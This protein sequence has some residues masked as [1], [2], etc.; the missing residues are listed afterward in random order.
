MKL[1][2]H[3]VAAC[4]VL[5]LWTEAN[6]ADGRAIQ[7][8]IRKLES[9]MRYERE[10]AAA[11]LRQANTIM[12]LRLFKE[13]F[14]MLRYEGRVAFQTGVIPHLLTKDVDTFL[15]KE[16]RSGFAVQQKVQELEQRA[17]REGESYELEAIYQQLGN[18][19][20]W[21]KWVVRARRD[22][23]YVPTYEELYA[24][25]LKLNER[26]FPLSTFAKALHQR[27]PRRAEADFQK[28]LFNPDGRMKLRGI[29]A[30]EAA[31]VV[32]PANVVL[33]FF[34]RADV[35]LLDQG[36]QF[37]HKLRREHL[38][39]LLSLVAS[40]SK[41]VRGMAE[42]RLRRIGHITS[43]EAGKLVANAA[44][45]E[46]RAEAWRLWWAKHKND[47]DEALRGRCVAVLVSEA[48]SKFTKRMLHE[49]AGYGDHA[50]VYPI[51][52]EAISS[53][54]VN[55]R[56]T[57]IMQLGNMA[58]R[59]HAAAADALIGHCQELAPE[60]FSEFA[61]CLARIKKDG[62]IESLFLKVLEAQ[63][64]EDTMWKRR[65]ARA[66]GQA[67]HRWAL[68]P[69]VRMIIEEG[70]SNA[71]VVL[72][73]V[74]GAEQAVPQL[75]E[76]MVLEADHNKRHAIRSAIEGVG[77]EGLAQ[78]L[79]KILPQAAE[80]SV[81]KGGPRYDVLKLM[82]LFP[83]PNAKPLL[84]GLLNNKNP[85]DQLGAAR[86]LGKLGDY[87]GVDRLIENLQPSNKISASYFTGYIGKALRMIGS[88]DTRRH[89]E[90][91][92]VRADL[93]V[94]KLTLHVMAQQGD[95][96]YLSFLEKQLTA[97]EPDIAATA[98]HEIG[99]LIRVCNKDKPERLDILGEDDL[100]PIRAM[101]VWAFFD[102]K[103]GEEDWSYPNH[104]SLKKFKGA[105]VYVNS[106]QHIEFT[107]A[108]KNLILLSRR[109]NRPLT[110]SD[111]TKPG[112]QQPY[113]VGQ[114]TRSVLGQ[115]MTISLN[116]NYG[117]ASCLFRRA[118]VKWQP[119][120]HIGGVIE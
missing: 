46:E 41:R 117:G 60:D 99:Y 59:G 101:F 86:V 103:I 67:G 1:L 102:Q 63:P 104:A 97:N 23:S 8:N 111:G 70:S 21:W 118:G 90:E 93:K 74:E 27:D 3:Y 92:F 80:G 12:V 40:P 85:W 109:R 18:D 6:S 56:R 120:G 49:F 25:L 14:P 35:A 31:R 28:L 36:D 50:E 33:E 51:F 112:R 72:P 58:A 65:I 17:E 54:D 4:V 42:Y 32:P 79:T 119:I 106:Y 96:A 68:E 44:T 57:A 61:G 64:G 26:G 76:A 37:V 9:T 114:I 87:S 30:L 95:P 98:R 16:F 83:D 29:W 84:L 66:L 81:F 13:A 38:E 7:N 71:A 52:F 20:E 107:T 78:K 22:L 34:E 115:Y 69:L 116:I 88:P 108:D 105:V 15:L 5:V 43:S 45:P 19:Y 48:K 47:S 91:L 77:A 24:M 73:H 55:L 2:T 110:A 89:L 82:E 10:Q 113:A 94:K 11:T 53:S 39:L 100:P 75:L 62:R